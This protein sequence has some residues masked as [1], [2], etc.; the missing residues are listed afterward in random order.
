MKNKLVCIGVCIAMALCA[1]APR[2]R[3]PECKGAKFFTEEVTCTQC[4]GRGYLINTYGYYAAKCPSCS[5]NTMSN[6]T[7]VGGK[8]RTVG[9]GKVKVQ[10]KCEHCKG[11]GW[12]EKASDSSAARTLVF[13]KAQWKKINDLIEINGEVELKKSRVKIVVTNE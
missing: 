8:V 10:H 11:A 13:T 7:T 2:E 6:T 5:K 4:E 3:C 12:V 1:D 9:T